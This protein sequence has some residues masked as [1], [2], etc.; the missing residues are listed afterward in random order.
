[1]FKRSLAV[2]W[3]GLALQ[4]LAQAPLP[5][6][7]LSLRLHRHPQRDTNRVLLLNQFAFTQYYSD[8][9]KSLKAG[10]ESRQLADSLKFTRGEADA[11]RQI[12]LAFWAQA[13]MPT[14]INYYLTG[15]RI[16]QANKHKQ[17]EADI[18]ANI[19][20]AYNGMGNPEEALKFLLQSIKLQQELKNEWREAAVINNIGDSYVALNDFTKARAAY[21]KGRDFAHRNNYKLGVTTNTRNIGNIL[22]KEGKYD[23][24]MA[25]YETALALS[26]E[27]DDSRGIVLTYKSMASVYLKRKQF[28]QAREFADRSLLASQKVKLRAFIRDSYELLT[29]ISE[30]EGNKNQAYEYFKLFSLYKDSVQN[31]RAVSDIAAARIRF[32][33]DQKQTEIELLKKEGELKAAEIKYQQSYLWVV[34][35][36]LGLTVIFLIMAIVSY[37][38]MRNQN[39]LLVQSQADVENKNRL[40]SHQGDELAALNEE[41]R[42]Q[43]DQ[44]IAQR[45]ELIEKNL[46]IEAMNLQVHDVNQNLEQLVFERTK[47]LEE[48]NKRLTDYSYFNAHELRSPVASILGLIDLLQRA[49]TD[50]ERTELLTHLDS[51]AKRLD[52]AIKGINNSL[53][54]GIH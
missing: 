48:Q 52:E 2:L 53:Q 36:S 12:G 45:D 50:N 4:S 21:Q 5:A 27:I 16:A 19:G 34:T 42:S 28:N 41:L 26:S 39:G 23:S 54:G 30:A 46:S 8:P 7:T 14:A 32:E 22:E 51:S 47:V 24:A 29:K 33:T 17:V 13:D 3:I 31:L 10:F 43:Q 11:F 20:T 1:M 15:L 6:D 37:R 40:L 18:I 25:H 44:V 9:V 49:Q 35:V 38:N